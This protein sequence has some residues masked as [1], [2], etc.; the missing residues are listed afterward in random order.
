MKVFPG[1]THSMT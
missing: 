1:G